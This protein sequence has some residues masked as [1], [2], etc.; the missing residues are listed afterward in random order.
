MWLHCSVS[1]RAALVRWRL[2]FGFGSCWPGS[3]SLGAAV[4]YTFICV[5]F[6]LCTV[7]VCVCVGERTE[8]SRDE[9][10]WSRHSQAAL[11][12]NITVCASAFMSLRLCSHVIFQ[13]CVF[14]VRTVLMWCLFLICF[15]STTP[16]WR[17]LKSPIQS[18]YIRILF[19]TFLS[20]IVSDARLSLSLS[21]CLYHFSSLSR[22]GKK[23]EEKKEAKAALQRQKSDVLS[24]HEFERMK[25]ERERWAALMMMM[26]FCLL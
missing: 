19:S 7:C 5:C 4:W 12:L 11:S 14:V 25:D 18:Y 8:R 22:F 3:I 2:V 6:L 10:F 1:C 20:L 9:S 23:K 17:L 15:H 16:R 24:D 13:P 26:I 21:F